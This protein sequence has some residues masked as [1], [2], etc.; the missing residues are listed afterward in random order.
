[1]AFK[2]T[3][4]QT[5]NAYLTATFFSLF[6]GVLGVDRFYMGQVWLG[7]LKLISFG[8]FGIWW[9]IDFIWIALG[10]AKTKSGKKLQRSESSEKIVY[11]GVIVF[12][13]LQI[14]GAIVSTISYGE[15]LKSIDKGIQDFTT[16]IDGAVIE[17]TG[18][19]DD[20]KGEGTI[21]ITFPEQK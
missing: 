17:A 14:F 4:K 20:K 1:M 13:V 10:N 6:L 8:G 2:A 9:L 15:T 12:V 19:G 18:S 21:M 7:I 5:D 16:A 11:I 3:V